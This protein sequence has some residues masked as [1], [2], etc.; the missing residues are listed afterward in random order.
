MRRRERLRSAG[1]LAALAWLA[2]AAASAQEAG[3]QPI[4][5]TANVAGQPIAVRFYRPSGP[6]PFPL[7][8]LSHGSPPDPAKRSGMGPGTMRRQAAALASG[9][10]AVAVPLRRGYGGQGAW[11]EGFG[12]CEAPDFRAGGLRTAEDIR[13]ALSVA[14]AQ[15]DVDRSRVVLVGHSAGGWGAVAAATQIPVLGVVSFAGGRGSGCLAGRP[16][17]QAALVEASGRLGRDSKAQQLWIY[18]ANDRSFDP[19]LAHR[20]HAAFVAAGG[21]AEFVAA[22]AYRTDGH[23][24]VD[25]V[26]AWRPAVERFLRRVGVLR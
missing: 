13:A 10:I 3:P 26:A 12:S 7:M 1:W 6:G 24:Y 4:D 23:A 17:A 5:L 15:P 2:A 25:D 21:R 9:G 8:V 19:D 20:L 18:S 16:D 22:P 14:L 11:A